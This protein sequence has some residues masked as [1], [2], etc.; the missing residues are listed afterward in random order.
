M[1]KKATNSAFTWLEE[2]C[3]DAEEKAVGRPPLD[4]GD[5]ENDATAASRD[6]GD[7]TAENRDAMERKC[8]VCGGELEDGQIVCES[9]KERI[10]EGE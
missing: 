9:C 8:P 5:I 3:T 1:R 7:N 10:D 2:E 6:A 4:E